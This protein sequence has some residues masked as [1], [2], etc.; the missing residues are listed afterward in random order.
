MAP[1]LTLVN[2][3]G[4]VLYN[5]SLAPLTWFRVGGPAE[6]LFMPRDEQDLRLFLT[7]LPRQIPITVIGVG[8]NL[9]V[10]DGGIEGAVIRLGR[11]F[12]A[13]STKENE[14]TAGAIV[15]DMMVARGAQKAGIAGLEF[16]IGVPGTVGGGLRMNAG[17]YGRE[18]KDI[19]KSVRAL[20]RAGK[21]VELT[22]ADMKFVYRNSGASEDLIFCSAT[23]AGERGDPAQSR[24]G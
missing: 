19:L 9:L 8:S 7:Q 18:F 6:V 22:P 23:F 10:R 5:E 3:K 15:P 2:L 16:L 20:D 13:V 12:S 4:P 14:V 17:A 1:R 24:S 11:E 21:V